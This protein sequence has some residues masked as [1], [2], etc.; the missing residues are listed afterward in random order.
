MQIHFLDPINKPTLEKIHE[1]KPP[2]REKV[3]LTDKSGISFEF[4]TSEF[5]AFK[6]DFSNNVS[7][8]LLFSRG[9]NINFNIRYLTLSYFADR[10]ENYLS[11]EHVKADGKRKFVKNNRDNS[12]GVREEIERFISLFRY[13]YSKDIKELMEDPEDYLSN[14]EF[15]ET[16]KDK[17]V[18]PPSLKPWVLRE[19]PDIKD[20]V[21][22]FLKLGQGYYVGMGA[23]TAIVDNKFDFRF[24]NYPLEVR[25]DN[26]LEIV[27]VIT[28]ELGKP[29]EDML[30]FYEGFKDISTET[31][32]KLNPLMFPDNIYDWEFLSFIEDVSDENLHAILKVAKEAIEYRPNYN[33]P[34]I[35][36]E[37]KKKDEETKDN[38]PKP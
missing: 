2:F 3:V 33:I 11:P 16:Y 18:Y 20:E 36:P 34:Y 26:A 32:D 28:P 8:Y 27:K 15:F 37:K 6:K 29:F 31:T 21:E 9:L 25:I 7:K 22:P 13:G 4:E 35:K 14:P 24:Q 12:F 23:P 17:D 30:H 10:L 38:K 19:V 1:G 5:E